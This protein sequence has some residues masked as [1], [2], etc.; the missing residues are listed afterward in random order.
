[1]LFKGIEHGLEGWPVLCIV[2]HVNDVGEV[3]TRAELHT[4]LQMK[5]ASVADGLAQLVGGE[6]RLLQGQTNNYRG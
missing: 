5:H 6:S 3:L 4:Y 2:V 1:M